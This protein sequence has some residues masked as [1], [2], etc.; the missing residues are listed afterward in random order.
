MAFTYTLFPY[1]DKK[2]KT[3]HTTLLCQS[4]VHENARV[5]ASILLYVRLQLQV[6]L[7]RRLHVATLL[8]VQP[9]T[10]FNLQRPFLSCVSVLDTLRHPIFPRNAST[11][12]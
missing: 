7:E 4:P 10:H 5:V 8:F 11:S 9:S 1:T 6:K 12:L 3:N 2:S